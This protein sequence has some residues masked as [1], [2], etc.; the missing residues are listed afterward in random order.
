MQVRL[1]STVGIDE[2]HKIRR[3]AAQMIY[4]PTQRISLADPRYVIARDNF[5]AGRGCDRSGIIGAVIRNDEETV[6]VF[7]L[8]FNV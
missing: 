2:E 6:A 8:R 3:R 5:R 4:R 7:Q 1:N